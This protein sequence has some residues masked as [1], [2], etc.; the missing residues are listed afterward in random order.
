MVK[1]IQRVNISSEKAGLTMNLKKTRVMSTGEQVNIL[2]DGEEISTVASNK[3][4]A[5]VITNDGYTKDEIKE[6]WAKQQWPNR[7]KL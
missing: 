4:L 2:A 6:A 1:L 3:F 7:Q 5:A